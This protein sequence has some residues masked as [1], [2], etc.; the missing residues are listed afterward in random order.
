VS[1]A[2]INVAKLREELLAKVAYLRTGEPAV[3][4]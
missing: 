4:P 1:P 2:A 3:G